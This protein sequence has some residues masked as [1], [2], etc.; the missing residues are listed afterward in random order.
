V[1]HE[2]ASTWCQAN[3]RETPESSAVFGPMICMETDGELMEIDSEV[4][5]AIKGSVRLREEYCPQ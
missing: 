4:P 3:G 5:S 1:Q 2:H